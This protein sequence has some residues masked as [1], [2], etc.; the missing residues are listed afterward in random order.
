MVWFGDGLIIPLL[1]RARTRG[2]Q[3]TD[4]PAPAR[5]ACSQSPYAGGPEAPSPPAGGSHDCCAPFV[6]LGTGRGLTPKRH[7]LRTKD[8]QQPPE[9]RAQARPDVNGVEREG[10]RA[11]GRS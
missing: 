9:A 1:V 4:V 3:R 6:G 11:V 2:G 10:E 7:R 5:R 8:L